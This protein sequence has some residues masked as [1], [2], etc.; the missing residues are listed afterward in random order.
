MFHT[1]ITIVQLKIRDKKTKPVLSKFQNVRYI[2]EIVKEIKATEDNGK[3][4][5]TNFNVI[6]GG[7]LE[8]LV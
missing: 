3:K 8:L 6:I 2:Y 5:L 1:T 4:N 7:K